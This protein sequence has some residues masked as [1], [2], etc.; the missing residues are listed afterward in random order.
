MDKSREFR[1]KRF[2]NY[3]FVSNNCL[4]LYKNDY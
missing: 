3:D 1:K 4:P 2:I